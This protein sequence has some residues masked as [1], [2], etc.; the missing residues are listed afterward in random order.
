MP[1]PWCRHSKSSRKGTRVWS[2]GLPF[3][4]L[5]PTANWD[6]KWVLMPLR[7]LARSFVQ[8]ARAA[9]SGRQGRLRFRPRSPPHRPVGDAGRG[10][11]IRSKPEAPRRSGVR[12][13]TIMSSPSWRLSCV[14]PEGRTPRGAGVPRG[15]WMISPTDERAETQG[16]QATNTPDSYLRIRKSEAPK[17]WSRFVGRSRT[18]EI[19]LARCSSRMCIR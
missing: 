4:E 6:T 7:D 9:G 18:F 16:C 13:T 3:V 15:E 12:T 8:S 17:A 19:P 5:R 1:R 10:D 11:I 2:E 14:I